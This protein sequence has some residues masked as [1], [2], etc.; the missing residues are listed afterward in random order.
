METSNKWRKR[1]RKRKRVKKKAY[2]KLYREHKS[3]D[4]AQEQEAVA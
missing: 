1:G 4:E 3:D 2:N